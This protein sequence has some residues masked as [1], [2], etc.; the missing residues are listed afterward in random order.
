MNQLNQNLQ[1]IRTSKEHIKKVMEK[2]FDIKTLV[3]SDHKLTQLDEEEQK[4]LK[5]LGV[6]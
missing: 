4:L 1:S 5:E 3:D 6:Q 2:T